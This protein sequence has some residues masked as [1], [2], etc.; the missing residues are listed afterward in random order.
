MLAYSFFFI[1]LFLNESF[2]WNYSAYCCIL[3]PVISTGL[4]TILLYIELLFF[5][6]TIFLTLLYCLFY[7]QFYFYY[8]F[9]SYKFALSYIPSFLLDYISLVL[10]FLDVEHD[11]P[12][13]FL[14]KFVFF[15]TV[16]GYYM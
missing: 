5:E 6:K 12:V 7:L 13:F 16:V 3:I 14:R 9:S 1:M 2:N 15:C 11:L 4:V 10:N 8:V